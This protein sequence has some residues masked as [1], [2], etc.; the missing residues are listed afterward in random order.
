MGKS[1]G[2]ANGTRVSVFG[3][4]SVNRSDFGM[5][6]FLLLVGKIT[7]VSIDVEYSIKPR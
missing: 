1:I 6:T 4:M 2:F 3:N 5:E 7:V